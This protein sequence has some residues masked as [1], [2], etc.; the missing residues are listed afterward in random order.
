MAFPDY[1]QFVHPVPGNIDL[2]RRPTV[3]VDGGFATVRSIGVGTPK[4]EA[5]IPT[6]HPDGYIMSD[7]EAVARY[8]QTGQH[9]GIFPT[10]AQ[11]NH[12]AERLHDQQAAQYGGLLNGL[13]R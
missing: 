9:L 1:R 5:L 2:N 7:D 13:L 6:V 4:G 3:P 10:V 11:A 8:E 12:Y